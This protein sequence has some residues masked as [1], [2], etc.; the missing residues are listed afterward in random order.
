M[1][2]LRLFGV[3]LLQRSTQDIALSLEEKRREEVLEL[4]DS[5]YD[6]REQEQDFERGGRGKYCP[7]H[8]L[9]YNNYH[10]RWQLPNIFGHPQAHQVVNKAPLS[11][12]SWE[13]GYR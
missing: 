5:M 9:A 8:H 10:V 7:T 2:L 6:V 4:L 12:L 13:R 3:K 11:S 1:W